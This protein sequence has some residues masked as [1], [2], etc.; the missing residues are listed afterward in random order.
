[1]ANFCG[2]C[3]TR[4]N[5]KTGTCPNPACSKYVPPK[6]HN[7]KILLL[8]PIAVL[9]VA[10]LL[11]GTKS[12]MRAAT[13][14]ALVAEAM[15]AVIPRLETYQK[16]AENDY[17]LRDRPAI[18]ADFDDDNLEELLL[19]DYGEVSYTDEF[20]DM[21]VWYTILDYQD[22]RWTNKRTQKI[23]SQS[24]AHPLGSAG[25][26]YKDNK[27]RLYTIK[28]EAPYGS[29]EE[30]GCVHISTV[31]I[32]DNRYLP[33]QKLVVTKTW[34]GYSFDSNYEEHREYSVNGKTVSYSQFAAELAEYDGLEYNTTNGDFEYTKKLP[35]VR[36]LINQ[37][38]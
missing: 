2:Q 22:G 10:G 14:K 21:A 24:F 18:L 12:Y 6:K 31:I 37:L 34:T 35:T 20:G 9:I 17:T 28:K 7:Y 29:S 38:Q 8:L 30:E 23:E 3:G 5:V 26:V 13:E 27:A 4:L 33:E 25:A 32:Y 1:M 19:Y 16:R 36:E 11:W 15:Q